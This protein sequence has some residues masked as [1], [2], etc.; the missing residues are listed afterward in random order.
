[1]VCK[2]FNFVNGWFSPMSLILIL[3]MQ[4]YQNNNCFFPFRMLMEM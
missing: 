1:M 3:K 2:F 4:K